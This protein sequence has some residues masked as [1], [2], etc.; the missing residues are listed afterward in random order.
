MGFLTKKNKIKLEANC[1]CV[2]YLRL[3]A[4]LFDILK[5]PTS[6]S[7]TNK[8]RCSFMLFQISHTDAFVSQSNK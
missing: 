7:I 5:S 4:G 6:K 1:Y 8:N 2:Q 3:T